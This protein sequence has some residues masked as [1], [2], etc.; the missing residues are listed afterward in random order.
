MLLNSSV[1]IVVDLIQMIDM[2]ITNAYAIGIDN[3]NKSTALG[4]SA[5]ELCTLA[6]ALKQVYAIT[7]DI[8]LY[9]NIYF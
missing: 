8:S 1:E 6:N 4:D 7:H 5:A 2:T 9:K 3:Y